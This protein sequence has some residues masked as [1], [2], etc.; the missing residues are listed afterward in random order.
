MRE[1]VNESRLRRKEKI[2]TF[3]LEESKLKIL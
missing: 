2:F 3:E 1:N